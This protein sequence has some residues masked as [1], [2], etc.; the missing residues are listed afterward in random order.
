MS[1]FYKEI[2]LLE[3]S[4]ATQS[5]CFSTALST[6]V[7]VKMAMPKKHIKNSQLWQY[8]FKVGDDD[9]HPCILNITL[10]FPY[11]IIILK[12]LP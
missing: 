4:T 11:I 10:S 5:D 1:T 7:H 12:R 3:T 8:P 9:L 6:T 2:N